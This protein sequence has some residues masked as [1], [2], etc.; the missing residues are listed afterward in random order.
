MC[1]QTGVHTPAYAGKPAYPGVWRMFGHL[2]SDDLKKHEVN[3]KVIGFKFEAPTNKILS[4]YLNPVPSYRPKS[5]LTIYGGQS[6][7]LNWTTFT[8]SHWFLFGGINTQTLKSIS[9]SSTELWPK[10]GFDHIWRSVGHLEL[11]D[12]KKTTQLYTF[13]YLI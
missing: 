6:A 10:I 1:R 5:V 2:E 3:K 9:L 12:L 7:I 4:Q 8:K 13:K 11:D